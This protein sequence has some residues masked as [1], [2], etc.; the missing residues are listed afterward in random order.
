VEEN[1]FRIKKMFSH[2]AGKHLQLSI[3]GVL[4]APANLADLSRSI[5]SR[6]IGRN[7]RCAAWIRICPAP[8]DFGSAIAHAQEQTTFL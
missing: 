4:V 6:R 7:V 1:A 8:I 3:L 2:F 5:A